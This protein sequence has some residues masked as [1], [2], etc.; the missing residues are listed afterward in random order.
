MVLDERIKPVQKQIRRHIRRYPD[1]KHKREPLESIPGI[2][3]LTAAMIM[4]EMGDVF[5]FQDAGQTAAC[6]GLT[7]HHRQSDSS[8]RG[9]SMLSETGAS[10]IRKALFMPALASMRHNPV[11]TAFRARLKENGKR[12]MVIVGAV[13][14]KLVYIA[15]GVL[16]SGKP[17][18]PA[19]AAAH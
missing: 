15:F 18:D 14:R 1:S 3:L 19:L 5:L 4:C 10:H 8:V 2:G 16:K 13:M 6:C 11:L 12:G 7:P 17:F 9:R